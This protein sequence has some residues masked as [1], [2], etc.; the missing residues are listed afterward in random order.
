VNGEAI[1]PDWVR[2]TAAHRFL[3]G[4]ALAHDLRRRIQA[5]LEAD[6]DRVLVL[7]LTGV[8]GVSHSFADEL[9]SPLSEWLEEGL[10]DR[11]VLAG[12]A[13][14]VIEALELVA[15][16]HGLFMPAVA[17]EGVPGRYGR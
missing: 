5:E 1:M 12:A 17:D 15:T 6:R 10:A 16:L 3:G 11:V 14:E 8:E 13:D 2:V 4:R 9:L 7:D